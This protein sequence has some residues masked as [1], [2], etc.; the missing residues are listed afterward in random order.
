MPAKARCSPIHAELV[1]TT[2]PSSN[3]VPTATTSQRTD[4]SDLFWF[5]AVQVSGGSDTGGPGRRRGA[6]GGGTDPDP[7]PVKDVLGTADHREQYRQIQQGDGD[8][9]LV[10][11]DQRKQ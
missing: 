11:V 2:W 8:A 4:N 9:R 7:S 3:S 1:S 6:R 10:I 5:R